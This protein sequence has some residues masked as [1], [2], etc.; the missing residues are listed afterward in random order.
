MCFICVF[1]SLTLAC[2]CSL[3]EFFLL[4]LVGVFVLC[5]YGTD[6]D[7]LLS[8]VCCWCCLGILGECVVYMCCSIG[9]VCCMFGGLVVHVCDMVGMAWCCLLLYVLGMCVVCLVCV[10]MCVPVVC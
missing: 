2:C 10:C 7:S 8:V 4:G 3:C 1:Q 6:T 9:H 5:L